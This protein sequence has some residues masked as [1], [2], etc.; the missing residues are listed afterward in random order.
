MINPLDNSEYFL[1]ELAKGLA[2]M[3]R[4][5][6]RKS[7][8]YKKKQRFLK[9]VWGKTIARLEKELSKKS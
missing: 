8:A 6:K 5:V 7:S 4:F 9:K 1:S 2:E 3:P